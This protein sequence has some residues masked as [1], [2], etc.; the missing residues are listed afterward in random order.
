MPTTRRTGL[1]SASAL[2][3]TALLSM[4]PAAEAAAELSEAECATRSA[5]GGQRLT[6]YMDQ[7]TKQILAEPGPNR[8]RLGEFEAVDPC[9]DQAKAEYRTTE[10]PSSLATVPV[11]APA[12]RPTTGIDDKPATLMLTDE[13]HSFEVGLSGRLHA[14]YNYENPNDYVERATG[15]EQNAA[16]GTEIR[17][18][19]IGVEGTFG[20]DLGFMLESDFADNEVGV[21]DAFLVYSGIDPLEFTL[22]QQKQAISMELQES[23]NDIMF[24][25]RSL[26][27]ALTGPLFDRAIGANLKGSGHDWSAQIGAYGDTIEPNGDR[28]QATEGYGASTRL[29]WAPINS[30]DYVIHL[31]TFAGVRESAEDNGVL[32]GQPAYSYEN[33]HMSNARIFDTGTIENFDRVYMGGLEFAAMAGPYSIQSEYVVTQTDRSDGFDD[34]NYDAGYVQLGWT[35]TG[36]SRVYR[37]SDGEFKGLRPDEPF[38]LSAG[39]YG[40]VELAGRFDY[41]DLN[42]RDVTGGE[43]TRATAAL[44]WYLNRHVRLMADYSRVINTEVS[45]LVTQDGGSVDGADIFTFRTQ[46]AF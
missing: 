27:N 34:L 23:S 31:G 30:E 25:E 41:A 13:S 26:V 20:K 22:G 11:E 8:V 40:A 18:A 28:E 12:P 44:N 3:L 39:T 38:D 7:S 14:D 29:T 2:G 35:L 9:A 33:T 46:W 5:A 6:L 21:K 10:E 1:W 16:T 45:P 4:P 17:R 37:G 43:G 36:E 15:A 32:D 24:T 19:R 42:D